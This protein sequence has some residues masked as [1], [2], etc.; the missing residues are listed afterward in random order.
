L[1]EKLDESGNFKQ[2]GYYDGFNKQR[3]VVQNGQDIQDAYFNIK[4][5]HKPIPEVDEAS[6]ELNIHQLVAANKRLREEVALQE[7]K[8]AEQ[9]KILA[10]QEVKINEL[11]QIVGQLGGS[12]SEKEMLGEHIYPIVEK[13]YPD[14]AG[15]I[16]GML[17]ELESAELY[18]LLESQEL[19]NDKIDEAIIV[20]NH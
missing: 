12:V 15:K 20:L 5:N 1:R 17:L 11:S 6:C 3:F 16:T 18:A 7:T 19:M 2:K 4:I 14:L 13:R 10:E 9:E 8:L